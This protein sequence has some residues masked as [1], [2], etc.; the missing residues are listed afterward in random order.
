M[1]IFLKI[2]ALTV[3]AA[4]V[5]VVAGVAVSDTR[6]PPLSPAS[7]LFGDDDVQIT[8]VGDIML[9]RYLRDT[10]H[11]DNYYLIAS[12]FTPLFYRS[13]MVVGNLEGTITSA[14][15][16]S[17]NTYIGD[18]GNTQ[19]TFAPQSLS[20]FTNHSF[21]LVSIGNNHITDFGRDGIKQTK[22]Y[23]DQSGIAYI[24]DPLNPVD[25]HTKSINGI[26]TT[27]LSFNQ[28]AHQSVEQT[29][30]A[31]RQHAPTSDWVIVYAHWGDEYQHAPSETQQRY[32]RAFA[33]AGADIIIG[34]H[35]HVWQRREQIDDT[36]IYYSLGNFIFDQFFSST[37]RCGG[38]VTLT[39]TEEEV[40]DEK[41][42]E[43]FITK[44]GTVK[45]Q[46]CGISA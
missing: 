34:S 32:A 10:H 12:D 20:F 13:D 25:T 27:F 26:T 41:V 22:N 3:V 6:L 4:I 21:D 40:A 15:S 39:L 31:I 17:S 46:D 5:A 1:K 29:T 8:F 2:S 9:D 19:F 43:A 35:P 37:V 28:F 11:P 24:G 44:D 33:D 42:R 14:T 18:S 23:L 38:V 45:H 16:V 36:I 7:L 30:Q